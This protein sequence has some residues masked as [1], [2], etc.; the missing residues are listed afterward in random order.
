MIQTGKTKDGKLS[1]IARIGVK[2][3]PFE[4]NEIGQDWVQQQQNGESISAVD[5][6][7]M[8]LGGQAKVAKSSAHARLLKRIEE[9]NQ[10]PLE[11][12]FT[13]SFLSC[14]ETGEKN[15]LHLCLIN[16]EKGY[17]LKLLSESASSRFSVKEQL[18]IEELSLPKLKALLDTGNFS[19]A[20]PTIKRLKHWFADRMELWGL[21][22][23]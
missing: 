9:E 10:M 4:L 8:V 3:I 12:D 2:Y 5:L 14:E 1:I 6:V 17:D 22:Y 15:K 16:Q 23:G 19:Q 13:H 7:G 21:A 20:H 11:L 18:A